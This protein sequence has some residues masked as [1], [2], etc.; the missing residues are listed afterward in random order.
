MSLSAKGRWEGKSQR[1]LKSGDLP[2]I[3]IHNLRGKDE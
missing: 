2:E 1:A 3:L